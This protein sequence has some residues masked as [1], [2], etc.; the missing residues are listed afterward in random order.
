M[1]LSVELALSGQ[2]P[3]LVIPDTLPS[4][5]KRR[6]NQHPPHT[7]ADWESAAERILLGL[8]VDRT[9]R[10]DHISRR[11]HLL[12][13]ESA[14]RL[15]R[16]EPQASGRGPRTGH[17]AATS[18]TSAMTTVWPDA[19]QRLARFSAVAFLPAAIGPVMV[20]SVGTAEACTRSGVELT[21]GL[22]HPAAR[23]D[24]PRRSAERGRAT[25]I[26]HPSALAD[27]TRP[28]GLS[29]SS[30]CSRWRSERARRSRVAGLAGC[31]DARPAPTTRSRP[32]QGSV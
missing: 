1:C 26:S 16:G 22:E 25:H 31:G 9:D 18:S 29:A 19:V 2:T 8:R 3:L 28:R 6:I 5:S 10:D 12:R 17:L 7:G 23:N 4:H 20:T 11:A 32:F 13:D 21:G 15:M 24:G 30:R 27:G 14:M